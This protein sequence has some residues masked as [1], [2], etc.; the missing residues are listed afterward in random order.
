MTERGRGDGLD[1]GFRNHGVNGVLAPLTLNAARSLSFSLRGSS[2][3][4]VPSN[5]GRDCYFLRP[6]L[7]RRASR[8]RRSFPEIKKSTAQ[9]INLDA[10]TCRRRFDAGPKPGSAQG[11]VEEE[12]CKASQRS[13]FN[14]AVQETGVPNV[15]RY[16]VVSIWCSVQSTEYTSMYKLVK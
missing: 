15:V 14:C 16:H 12:R 9:A 10:S 3:G 2:S 4:V 7:R 1:L 5:G 11:R 8:P 13:H 6:R